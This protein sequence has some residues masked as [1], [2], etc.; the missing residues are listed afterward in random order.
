M[1]DLSERTGAEKKGRESNI[2]LKGIILV[3]GAILAVVGGVIMYTEIQ[4][5]LPGRTD[6]LSSKYIIGLLFLIVGLG[7]ALQIMVGPALKRRRI[8]RQLELTRDIEDYLDKSK[9]RKRR[10]GGGDE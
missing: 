4:N 5:T 1:E 8:K 2:A 9:S 10:R 6:L 3:I 7:I